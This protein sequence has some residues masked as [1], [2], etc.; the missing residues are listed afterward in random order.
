MIAQGH[1]WLNQSEPASVVVRQDALFLASQG[2]QGPCS[3]KM[4]AYRLKCRTAAA[5]TFHALTHL[6]D[7]LSRG[8]ADLSSHLQVT[9]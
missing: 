9:V 8:T 5:T 7:T 1:L 2:S 6:L 3:W 4:V